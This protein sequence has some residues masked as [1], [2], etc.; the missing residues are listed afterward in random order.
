MLR[1]LLGCL[2]V[3]A[4]CCAFLPAVALAETEYSLTVAGVT[5][6]D[7][8]AADLT[9][10]DGVSV[11]SG[12]VAKFV[13]ST[14]TLVL[15]DATII[16]KTVDGWDETAT[17]YFGDRPF[18][19]EVTGTCTMT[20]KAQDSSAQGFFCSSEQQLNITLKSGATLNI[21]SGK[22]A[23]DGRGYG[24]GCG[25]LSISGKGTV[26]AYAQAAS[27]AYALNIWEGNLTIGDGCTLNAVGASGDKNHAGLYLCAN[28]PVITMKG[29]AKATFTGKDYGM[30]LDIENPNN[31]T[32]AVTVKAAKGW[33]GSIT[34]Y[35]G[36]KAT[37]L[38]DSAW[39]MV[40]SGTISRD[41]AAIGLTG[42][43]TKS[44]SDGKTAYPNAKYNVTKLTSK[45]LEFT[46][47]AAG[48]PISKATVGTIANQ[49]YT[50]KAIKPALKVTYNGKSL[51]QGTDYTLS[52]ANNVK[53]GTATVTI[54][55]IGAYSGTKT[56]TFKIVPGPW[57][58]VAGEQRF[59]TSALVNQ[60]AF[61]KGSCTWAVVAN[62][63]DFPDALA[64]S[65]LAGV[66]DGAVVLVWG[67]KDQLNA[68]ARSELKRL[69]VKNVYIMGGTGSV[70]AGIEKDIKG[71]G[72]KAKRLAG[73]NRIETSMLA[74]KAAKADGSKADTVI[75]TTCWDYPDTLSI[76]PWSY[77][78][79]APV[80]LTW[81]DGTMSKDALAAIKAGGYKKAIVVSS[82]GK[83]D[84]AVTS[85]LKGNTGV[86]SVTWL[87]G[88]TPY[89][90][91]DKVVA[92]ELGNGLDASHPIVATYAKGFADALGGSALA[93]SKD[94]IIVLADS[95]N[96]PGIKT[97][98]SHKNERVLGY[99]LGG[100]ST[101]S[102]AL[103]KQISASTGAGGT[104]SKA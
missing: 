1:K 95:S 9:A 64:A 52:Y 32:S 35:G 17:M 96:D 68:E 28:S 76:S 57:K 90:T 99:I 91:N 21:S 98:V 48:T 14:N 102:D 37:A 92:W 62:G 11:K 50:G 88:S 8:N 34:V 60:Q 49:P 43:S 12:G 51:K 74:A 27:G 42:Y 101:I 97:L 79:G 22:V 87:T 7:G 53:V 82:G 44:T 100:P 78:N 24:L 94:S 39:T 40:T 77:A 58:R 54:T 71:M 4:L 2:A 55:G 31:T 103:A 29:S 38:S 5:V 33:T 30:L 26:N 41:T 83:V 15:K 89:A 47:A 72:I 56:A 80:V 20:G 69:G 81:T 73:A 93:G 63:A 66:H 61:A 13:P 70:S 10:I 75:I 84:T 25:G 19:L 16:N 45:R 3:M 6:T 23:A 67:T 65:G 104:V 85:Q 59:E 18:N 46:P 36:K 86:K